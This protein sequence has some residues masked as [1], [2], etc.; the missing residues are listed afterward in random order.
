MSVEDTIDYALNALDKLFGA[1]SDLNTE[2]E[3]LNARKCQLQAD[4]EQV[5]RELDRVESFRDIVAHIDQL[6]RKVKRN[7]GEDDENAPE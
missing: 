6:R 1:F 2:S 7:A 5:R 3:R 4:L